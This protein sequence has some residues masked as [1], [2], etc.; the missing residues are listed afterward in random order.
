M[1]K[2]IIFLSTIVAACLLLL[3]INFGLDN[4]K[5]AEDKIVTYLENEDFTYDK[6]GGYYKRN[7]SNNTMSDYYDDVKNEKN[8]EFE[9][10]YFHLGLTRI[11]EEKLKSNKKVSEEELYENYYVLDKV[12]MTY[13]DDIYRNY[14]GNYNLTDELIKYKYEVTMYSSTIIVSGEYDTSDSD[15]FTCN[16]D[17]DRDMGE[18]KV[19]IFCLR[20]KH[21]TLLFLEQA[22]DITNN[23]KF[24][25]II[26][27]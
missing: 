21:E 11:N 10:L 3:I 4:S 8:A 9:E 16:I 25:E 24:S 14:S 13:E 7:Y 27:N 12:K 22:R 2:S 26:K 15:S 19:E 23:P 6:D 1:K 20:A 17:N 5:S 18:D